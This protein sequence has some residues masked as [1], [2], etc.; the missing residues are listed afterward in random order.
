MVCSQLLALRSLHPSPAVFTCRSIYRPWHKPHARPSLARRRQQPLQMVHSTGSDRQSHPPVE[1]EQQSSAGSN[2][3]RDA[4]GNDTPPEATSPLVGAPF[5]LGL[6]FDEDE[7][8]SQALISTDWTQTAD[9]SV[10]WDGRAVPTPGTPFKLVLRAAAAAIF[11]TAGVA[12]TLVLAR[13]A[14]QG[15]IVVPRAVS[16]PLSAAARTLPF[17]AHREATQLEHMQQL[18]A[19]TDKDAIHKNAVSLL[20]AIGMMDN[21]VDAT[22]MCTRRNY[23]RW[24]LS[25][26][27]TLYKGQLSKRILP[28]SPATAASSPIAF[29]DVHISDPDFPVIQGLAEAGL[30]PSQLDGSTKQESMYFRP[31]SYLT[32]EEMLQWKNALDHRSLPAAIKNDVQKRWGFADAHEISEEALPAIL[33]DFDYDDQS[34]IIRTFGYTRR[35][36][37]KK[38]VTV[39]QAAT[40]LISGAA[41]DGAAV[42]QAEAAERL[43]SATKAEAATR[44]TEAAI[45]PSREAATNTVGRQVSSPEGIRTASEVN[46]PASAARDERP[47]ASGRSQTFAKADST[48]QRSAS[49]VGRAFSGVVDYITIGTAANTA[50]IRS[51]ILSAFLWLRYHLLSSTAAVSASFRDGSARISQ[52]FRRGGGQAG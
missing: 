4:H 26:S 51:T 5:G 15:R 45:S 1:V 18:A 37:P 46:K 7:K 29:R 30:I 21:G 36:Q 11:V 23:A 47:E 17:V 38:A 41:A 25:A 32:R 35:L 39:S 13:S 27:N 48:V 44:A 28:A 16:G 43:A 49:D 24:L 10:D 9:Y 3:D 8:P 19:E 20:K 42:K 2:S 34:A 33:R 14:Q 6:G 12:L 31:D 52:S 50:R 40:T 22:S